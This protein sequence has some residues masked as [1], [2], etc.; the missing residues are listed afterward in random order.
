M[1]ERSSLG[2]LRSMIGVQIGLVAT[3]LDLDV[4]ETLTE[5]PS[6]SRG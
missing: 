4:P 1:R 5:H 6:A 3:L 2:E